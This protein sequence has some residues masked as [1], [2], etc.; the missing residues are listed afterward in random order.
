MKFHVENMMCSGCTSKVQEQLMLLEG[1]EE[2]TVELNSKIATI[3]GSADAKKVI[4]A[5][6][7]INHPATLIDESVNS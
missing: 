6:S 4:E 3:A 5:L 7:A 2:A 1:V